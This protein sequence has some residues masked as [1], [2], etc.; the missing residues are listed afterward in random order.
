MSNLRWRLLAVPAIIATCVACASDETSTGPEDAEL[1]PGID[2]SHDSTTSQAY[3]F[4][5]RV[6]RWKPGTGCDWWCGVCLGP[7]TDCSNW[8][9]G[10]HNGEFLVLELTKDSIAPLVEERCDT[11]RASRYVFLQCGASLPETVHWDM[12]SIWM[13]CSRLGP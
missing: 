7:A 3:W 11:V 12:A 1:P 8:G 9:E 13:D 2:V 4:S 6:L 10:T 5:V